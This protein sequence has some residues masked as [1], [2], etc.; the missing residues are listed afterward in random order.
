MNK[1][2]PSELIHTDE[3]GNV[4]IGEKLY[5]HILKFGS[6]DK[7]GNAFVFMMSFISTNNLTIDSLQ[8]L[9]IVLKPTADFEYPICP[10][11][12]ID[13]GGV[14]D[15]NYITYSNSV[16]KVSSSSDP[17]TSAVDIFSVS[18]TVTTL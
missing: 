12:D 4:T 8:N 13:N 1:M 6:T 10:A 3:N 18:D 2:I 5:R 16:W 14:L 9:T 17:A 11:I 7:N 15:Y